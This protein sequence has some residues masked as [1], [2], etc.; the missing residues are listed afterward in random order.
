MCWAF[1]INLCRSCG[2]D[3]LRLHVLKGNFDFVLHE[4]PRSSN[5]APSI[6]LDVR[7][8]ISQI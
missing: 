4:G 3:M 1:H 8:C 5:C 2:V 6:L 7:K